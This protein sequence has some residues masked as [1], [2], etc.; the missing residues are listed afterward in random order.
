[1]FR[2]PSDS[3]AAQTAVAMS[4]KCGMEQTVAEVRAFILRHGRPPQRVKTPNSSDQKKETKLRTR[5]HYY[6]EGL[7]TQGLWKE[8]TEPPPAVIGKLTIEEIL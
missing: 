5:L 8:P 3:R 1:M 4:K 7:Q 6:Q 2:V